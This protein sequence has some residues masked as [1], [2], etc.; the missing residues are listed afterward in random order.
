MPLH[1]QCK[2]VLDQIAAQGG[3]PMEEMTPVEV[4]E[5]RARNAET[6]AAL[7]GPE[8]PVPRVE[9]RTIPGPRGPIPIRVY[10]PGLGPRLPV[11]VYFHGGGWVF[12]NIDGVDRPCRALANRT[13]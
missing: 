4:R 7:A 11:Y 2:A 6:F 9:N 5:Q 3:R 13:G 1:P 12:G 8:E 10:W